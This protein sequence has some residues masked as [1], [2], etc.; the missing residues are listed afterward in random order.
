VEI[1][2]ILKLAL[3]EVANGRNPFQKDYPIT[4]DKVIHALRKWKSSKQFQAITEEDEE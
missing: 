2:E 4:R 3:E 1:D